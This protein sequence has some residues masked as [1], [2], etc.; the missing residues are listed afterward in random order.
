MSTVGHMQT[1]A[2]IFFQLHFDPVKVRLPLVALIKGDGD[3]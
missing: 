1:V 2:G 3:A